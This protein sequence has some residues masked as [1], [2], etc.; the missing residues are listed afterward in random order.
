MHLPQRGPPVSRILNSS[1]ERKLRSRIGVNAQRPGRYGL[2]RLR[3]RAFVKRDRNLPLDTTNEQALFDLLELDW[4]TDPL[5]SFAPA[6][7]DPPVAH[8]GAIRDLLSGNFRRRTA[9]QV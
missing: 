6:V 7:G 1:T 9:A 4:S 2:D 3:H 8:A 5:A